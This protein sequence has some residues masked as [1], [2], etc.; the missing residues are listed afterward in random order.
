M[1]DL[2]CRLMKSKKYTP[3]SYIPNNMSKFRAFFYSIVN[4]LIC[5]FSF[6]MGIFLFF[7]GSE[8]LQYLILYFPILSTLESILYSIPMHGILSGKN[9]ESIFDPKALLFISQ[10]KIFFLVYLFY[11]QSVGHLG[12]EGFY[13]SVKRL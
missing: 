11:F 13:L 8:R 2:W 4:K 6:K 12:Y 3:I 10:E 9:T 5:E 1:Q 7:V